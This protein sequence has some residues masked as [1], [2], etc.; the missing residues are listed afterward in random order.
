MNSKII[1]YELCGEHLKLMV[2]ED[3][4]IPNL[5]TEL[6]AA[7]LHMPPEAS[8]LDLGCG[9]AP[10]AIFAARKGAHRVCAVDIMPQACAYARHNAELNGV[11]DRVEV[12]NGDLF[13]PIRGQKF[14]VIID[15][16]SGMAEG[17]SRISPWY[18]PAIPTGGHDGT[19]P[20]IRMIR[21]ARDYLTE[22]GRLYFPILSLSDSRKILETAKEIYGTRLRKI[23]QKMVPFCPDFKLHMK[24][25]EDMKKEGIIDFVTRRS[26]NLWILDV[27]EVAPQAT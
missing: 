4:F 1:D 19:G 17:V 23:A 7:H 11:A 15:D 12:I 8:V 5:T 27:Y 2:G 10:L 6:M 16:V 13:E 22:K 25:L 9:V 20:T 14:D 21:E 24:A 18:P 26:R 3:A